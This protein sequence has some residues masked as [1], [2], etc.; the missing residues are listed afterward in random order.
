MD[1][2]PAYM[3][4]RKG[5]E[6]LTN[7]GPSHKRVVD[8]TDLRCFEPPTTLDVEGV[9]WVQE[10]SCL[11]EDRLLCEDRGRVE[12]FV[13]GSYFN[14]CAA[15]VQGRTGAAKVIPYNYRHRRIEQVGRRQAFMRRT[16]P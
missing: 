11:S 8:V 7:V 9:E 3:N 4:F 15:I 12:A 16:S 14:E 6:H 10:P 5:L 2:L 13:R 1:G